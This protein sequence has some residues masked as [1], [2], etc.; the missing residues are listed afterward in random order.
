MRRSEHDREILLIALPSLGAL[1]AEPLYLL[2]DTAIVGHLGTTQ[3]AALAL[4]ATVLSSLVGLCN[5]LAYGTTAQVARLHGAGE[6]ERA[7]DL[8]A[9]AIWL[10]LL[11][12][13]ALVTLTVTL[14]GPVI[15]LLGGDGEVARLATRYLR[16]AALGLPFAL[17]ALAGQGWLRGVGD[18][19]TPLVIIVVANLVNIALEVLFVYG[20]GMGLDGSALGTVIAQLGMGAAF[21]W[22]LLRAPATTR[23]PVWTLMRPM[24]RMG[25]Q[26]VVRTA[27]LL[28]AFGV[29]SAVLA[30]TSD[31]ALAA[32]QVAFELFVFLALV[33]DALAIAG[34]VL[35][36]R[37]LGAGE[38][39]TARA[40]G[41][42]LIELSLLGGLAMT[43]ALLALS[44]VI[45]RIFTSDPAVLHQLALIWP[46]FACMQPFAAVVFAL[47]GILIGAG[48]TRYI[49]VAMAAASAVAVS[50]ELAAL[51]F[52]WG[53]VG[54]WC[55]V[56][57]L[58]AVRLATMA[59]ALRGY[60]L[61]ARRRDAVKAF[62]AERVRGAVE[63]RRQIE[64]DT[65][66][67]ALDLGDHGVEHRYAAELLAVGGDDVPRRPGR[68]G[69]LEHV[70]D[71]RAVLVPALAV[72]PVLVGQ[73]PALE[74]ILLALAE[75]TQLLLGRDVHPDLHDDDALEVQRALELDDLG[76]RALPLL[77]RRESLDAL[78]EH[79]AVPAAVEH[80]HAA[81]P[82]EVLDEALEIEV[83]LLVGRGRGVLRDAHVAGVERRDEPLD[84]A[85]LAGG[86]PALEDHEQAG[87]ETAV[88][89]APRDREPQ[90]G[91]PQAARRELLLVVLGGDGLAEVDGVEAWHAGDPR[92][93]VQ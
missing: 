73:L 2:A 6:R 28:L 61:G 51:A 41:R 85:A 35:V 32:N 90:L 31:A 82:R 83:A 5:F 72:A 55:G 24:T 13:L 74:R 3:L 67:A 75:A 52:D 68:L 19:R 80:G 78:D 42:R 4:A 33:L 91:E 71:G 8:G 49:A 77:G 76:V 16:I 27:S 18:L 62:S 36:G 11:V 58:M 47:D 69:A 38:A 70:L 34:Q 29:A 56:L 21:A 30:R 26:I 17:L 50:I 48:D 43:V 39:D 37:S 65:R 7:G 12:G 9:Q 57:A 63:R 10:A 40:A 44:D 23:R 92:R 46:L 22:W 66:A 64:P 89:Q 25:A 84:G 81:V 59:V 53:I 1:A 54:V 60:S 93:L 45:P 86:V 87:A 88:A 79:A 20:L 14:A 15:Q